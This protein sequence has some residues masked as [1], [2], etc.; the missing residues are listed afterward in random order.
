[1]SYLTIYLILFILI[2]IQI[3]VETIRNNKYINYKPKNHINKP[4]DTN[5]T[6]DEIKNNLSPDI[7]KKDLNKS[8]FYT[9]RDFVMI[10][11]VYNIFQNLNIY[12]VIKLPIHAF[13]QGTLGL[14]LWCIA[15]DCGHGGF[16]DYKNVNFVIGLIS[17]SVI[18]VPYYPWRLTHKNHHKHTCDIDKDEVHF[19]EKKIYPFENYFKLIF[20]WLVYCYIGN[21]SRNNY[22]VIDINNPL[23]KNDF[24]KCL[25]SYLTILGFIVLLVKFMGIGFIIKYYLPSVFVTYIWIVFI[26]LLHH[27]DES[28]VWKANPKNINGIIESVD[29][30]YGFFHNIIHNIGTHQVHHLCPQIPHYNL[31]KAT[32]QFR[33]KFPQLCKMSTKN[34]IKDFITL[35][36]KEEKNKKLFKED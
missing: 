14:S 24:Y 3:T 29:R 4:I 2:S 34:P 32:Y 10:F 12:N 28:T 11:L 36:N 1:M 13:I 33:K 31:P 5:L 30:N 8:I 17:N 22:S 15:H 23:F 16:S 26:T 21:G 6:I 27:M 18:L 25:V 35:T 9:V 19:P 7:F 20:G